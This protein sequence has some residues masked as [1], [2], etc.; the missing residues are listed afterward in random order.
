MAQSQAHAPLLTALGSWDFK[1]DTGRVLDLGCGNGLLLEKVTLRYPAL[2]PCG[3]EMDKER[4]FSAYEK[5][6][7]L[8]QIACGDLGDTSLWD[9]DMYD[10][11]LLYPGRL[12]ELSD[13]VKV[14][15]R[16][17]L[18]THSKAILLYAY[19][20]NFGQQ[21]FSE[22]VAELDLP[23]EW[24]QWPIEAQ[25]VAIAMLVTR[26]GIV[27]QGEEDENINERTVVSA[28]TSVG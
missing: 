22:M 20:D 16:E 17:H 8:G 4:F 19:S 13:E 27:E 1:G 28:C 23:S 21:P 15:A 9:A 24:K 5:L 14:R 7:D 6:G 25:P 26:E 11:V 2:E 12:T 3:V 10:L 18:L